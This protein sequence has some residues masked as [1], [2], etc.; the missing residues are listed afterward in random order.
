MSIDTNNGSDG[1]L[2]LSLPFKDDDD[3]EFFVVHVKLTVWMS[4]GGV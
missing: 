2:A 1:I 4:V 3:D